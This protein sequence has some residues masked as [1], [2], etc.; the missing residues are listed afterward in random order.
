VTSGTEGL[1]R[2]AE[3]WLD[4]DVLVCTRIAPVCPYADAA[5]VEVGED[6][7]PGSALDN[8]L[9]VRFEW[10]ELNWSYRTGWVGGMEARS[11][12]QRS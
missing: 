1:R 7:P 4:A 2:A 5:R 12:R 10:L 3:L 11:K 9:P 8:L 6:D